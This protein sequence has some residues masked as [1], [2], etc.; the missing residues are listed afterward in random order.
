YAAS[1]RTMTK[2]LSRR[3]FLRGAGLA[4]AL[5]FLDSLRP[6]QLR[7]QLSPA[8][9]RLFLF[10]CP[11]GMYM[12]NWTP[13]GSGTSFTLS[14]ILKPLQPYQSDILVISG[15]ENSAVEGGNIPDGHMPSLSGFLTATAPME[16]PVVNTISVDQLA[17]ATLKQYTGL[18]SLVLGDS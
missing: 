3:R 11:N 18:P 9:K 8:P 10:N 7:A 4:L 2:S 13:T 16:N 6:K 1:E 12:P 14:T 15:L 17:A 5:P